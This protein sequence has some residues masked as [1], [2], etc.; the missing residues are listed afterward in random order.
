[1]VSPAKY[2]QNDLKLFF[3]Q[4]RRSHRKYFILNNSLAFASDAQKIA[5]ELHKKTDTYSRIVVVSFNFLWKPILDFLRRI[6]ILKKQLREPNWLNKDDIRNIFQLE[7]FEEIKSGNRFLLPLDLGVVSKF[8][9]KFLA[10]LPLLNNICLTS[11]QIFRKVPKAKKYSVSVIIPARNE[12]GNVKGILK[13]IPRLGARTEVIFVEGWSSDR[14]FEILKKE[15]FHPKPKWLR[16][17]LYKQRGR[18][19]KDAVSLGFSKAKND[20]LMIL[21]AD[22]T[23]NPLDLTKFYQALASGRAELANGSRLVYP[24][25]K[26]AM[27]SLNYLGNRIFSL[28]FSYLLGQKIKDTL[29]GTKALFR[30]DYLN[31][32]KHEP[33]FGNFDP[34]G[35]FNLIFGAALENLKIVDIPVRYYERKYGQTN[36][37]RFRNGLQL[38]KMT[39]LAAKRIKYV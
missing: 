36:I 6:G 8:V 29:C 26:Q 10:Q 39:Y 31:I 28:I 13:K 17:F 1:M 20:I 21:D 34:F 14:T 32:K 23:V 27:R 4:L 12:E 25:E 37:S 11:Y 15:I 24:L 19:K 16:A 5:Q 7:G 18:G 33:L 35:D 38:L 3:R 22:L 2:Y 30:K 9:N